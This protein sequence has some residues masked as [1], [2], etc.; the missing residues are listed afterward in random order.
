V[1]CVDR[2]RALRLDALLWLVD[3]CVGERNLW[4]LCRALDFDS[5]FGP[6]FSGW[7]EPL[8]CEMVAFCHFCGE[9]V[10]GGVGPTAS[11]M[12]LHWRVQGAAV[13][14]LGEETGTFTDTF[15]QI[16]WWGTFPI[17][18]PC[19]PEEGRVGLIDYLR[20]YVPLKNFSLV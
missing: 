13:G 10:P 2:V 17:F 3:A 19:R 7:D 15:W 18:L 11:A 20:F 16:G 4:A 5:I 12:L 9:L 1:P 6:G 8:L 14:L